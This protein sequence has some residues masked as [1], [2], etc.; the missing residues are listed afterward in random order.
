MPGHD[1]EPPP[2]ESLSNSLLLQALNR[3]DVI[4]RQNS[5]NAAQNETIIRAQQHADQSRTDMHK[6][7]NEISINV[8]TIESE[9]GTLQ[10]LRPIVTMLRDAHIER[11]VI[12]KVLGTVARNGYARASG[13]VIA[14]GGAAWHW[15]TLAGMVRRFFS[16]KVGGP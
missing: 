6:R 8:A 7:L 2:N 11:S 9:V 4:E 3:L 1:H 14:A 16:L 15:D 12:R 10:E 13:A 5:R